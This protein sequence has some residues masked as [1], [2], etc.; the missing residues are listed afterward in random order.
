MSKSKPNARFPQRVEAVQY[1]ERTDIANDQAIIR[2]G[3]TLR[4]PM[5]TYLR[6]RGQ[7]ALLVDVAGIS[8]VS[9]K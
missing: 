2:L 8:E 1:L 7:P 3:V 4:V 6:Y 5:S 9:D